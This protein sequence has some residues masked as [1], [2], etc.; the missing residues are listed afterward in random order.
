LAVYREDGKEAQ[1]MISNGETKADPKLDVPELAAWTLVA[2][3]I[4]NLDETLNK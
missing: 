4:L 3:Q 1:A 2:S